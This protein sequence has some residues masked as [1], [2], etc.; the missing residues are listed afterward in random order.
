MIVLLGQVETGFLG[1]EAF[2]EVDLPA[3]YR[4]I[5][6]WA[7]RTTEADGI[8]DT[9]SGPVYIPFTLPGESVTADLQETRGQLVSIDR[10]SSD[11]VGARNTLR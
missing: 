6:K 1:K 2:Q 10:A 11:R 9:Q 7:T 4:P 3:F 8:A 5:T